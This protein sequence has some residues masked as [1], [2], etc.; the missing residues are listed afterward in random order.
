[1]A[2]HAIY[3]NLDAHIVRL[4]RLAQTV[5]DEQGYLVIRQSR[6][7]SLSLQ[8][9]DVLDANTVRFCLFPEHDA[10]IAIKLRCIG[11]ATA[12]DYI[13]QSIRA[14]GDSHGRSMLQPTDRFYKVVAE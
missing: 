11:I 12:E 4:S 13:R 14:R 5:Q 7:R 1:M 3:M 9:G 2:W 10:L 6:R 8:P